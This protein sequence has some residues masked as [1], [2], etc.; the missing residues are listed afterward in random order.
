MFLVIVPFLLMI[1]LV[2]GLFYYNPKKVISAFDL[3]RKCSVYLL[4]AIIVVAGCATIGL[5][6]KYSSTWI[7]F[8]YLILTSVIGYLLY[9]FMFFVLSDIVKCFVTFNKRKAGVFIVLLSLFVSSYGILN[10]YRFD[11]VHKEIEIAGLE[12]DLKVAVVAD[13]QLGGHR[14]KDYLEKVVDETNAFNADIILIP[15][16]LA[17]SNAILEDENFEALSRLN[18]PSYFILGNHDIYIDTDRLLNILRDNNIMI[19][20]NDVVNTHGIQLVGLDYMKADHE[21]YDMHASEGDETI[22]DTMGALN[23]SKDMPVVVMHHSPIGADYVREAGGDLYIAGHTHAG[24]QVF[25]ITILTKM[26][27]YEYVQGLYQDGPLQIYVSSGVGTF[28]LPMRIGTSNELDLLT[29]K[30]KGELDNETK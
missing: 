24:G 3:Q 14:G 13:V 2:G 21:T 19:L 5:V 18:A 11:V 17:D 22:K 25:P 26:F 23:L 29:L 16:D 28:N 6:S 8:S 20:D 15:G 4:N 7:D 30:P 9:L 12:K 27:F 10:A 1:I